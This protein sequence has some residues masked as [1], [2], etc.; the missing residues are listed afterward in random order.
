ML[1][2]N[3]HRSSVGQEVSSGV[4]EFD[5]SFQGDLTQLSTGQ[6]TKKSEMVAAS[7]EQSKD[8]PLAKPKRSTSDDSI[9][10]IL[11]SIAKKVSMV[12]AIYL[13][14]YMNFSVAWLITPVI[15]AVT[16]EYW[17]KTNEIKREV[18]KASAT[19][20]EK[21]VIL[22]R[23]SDLPAWVIRNVWNIHKNDRNSNFFFFVS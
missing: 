6:E 17:N 14:G 20:N 7:K 8:A 22:A 12:G 10:T 11:Y 15:L 3:F 4:E 21:D 13:V 18:A 19:A 1:K 23:I 16:R 5:D 9:F 2:M